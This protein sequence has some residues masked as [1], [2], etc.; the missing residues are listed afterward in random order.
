MRPQTRAVVASQ[1][2]LR[3]AGV[4][5]RNHRVHGAGDSSSLP[6]ERPVAVLTLLLWRRGGHKPRQV[7]GLLPRKQ[8]GLL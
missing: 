5:R 8:R 6:G 4:L 1:Q 7:P 3:C 2:S